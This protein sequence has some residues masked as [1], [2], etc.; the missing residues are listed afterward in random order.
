MLCVICCDILLY[1]FNRLPPGI[2]IPNWRESQLDRIPTGQWG[3]CPD[4]I[5]TR[6]SSVAFPFLGV[7]NPHCLEQWCGVDHVYN[8]APLQKLL[9]PTNKQKCRHFLAPPYRLFAL[10]YSFWRPLLMAAPELR[11]ATVLKS[12][13]LG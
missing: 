3:F 6:I 7:W 9:S 10:L 1:I 11:Y 5:P 13:Q 4:G 12:P 2:P 8:L